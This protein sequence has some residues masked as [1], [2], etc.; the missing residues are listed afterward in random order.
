MIAVVVPT[1]REEC[2]TRWAEEWATQFLANSQVRV[3]VVEDNPHRT[4]GLED[5]HIYH[6][7]WHNIERDF[8]DDNWIIPRRTDCVRSYGYWKAWEMGAE[9]IVTM[10]DDCYPNSPGYLDAHMRALEQTVEEEA[11]VSTIDG[12]KPR[13][14]P[15]LSWKRV[16]EVVLN[17]GLWSGVPDL[18]A[19]TQLASQGKWTPRKQVI[20]HGMYFPMCGMNIAFK[21]EVVPAMYF[22]L[23]G[24]GYEYDRFG[25]IWCG[26]IVK[27]I[28][29]HLGKAI[30]SGDP[31]VHHERASNVWANLRKEAAALERN[32]VFWSAVDSVPLTGNTWQECY[33]EVAENLPFK[34]DYWEKLH[35]AMKIW[36]GLF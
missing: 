21:R 27:R 36:A 22:L 4:F 2:I 25:D 3:I 33:L 16:R 15:Y 5:D 34:G 32:E 35:N 12:L 9:V 29:D 31:S 28:A 23:M 6:F 24:Q 19:V 20:P 11:W 1:I 26:I 17:H 8:R 14:F 13:G 10:D 7:T 18:D 30:M